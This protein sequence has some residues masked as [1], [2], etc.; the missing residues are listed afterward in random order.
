MSSRNINPFPEQRSVADVLNEVKDELK[1][2]A[3]TRIQMLRAEMN[4]RVGTLKMS[5]PM[6]SIGAFLGVV[7][8]VWF[9][10][11]LTFLIAQAFLPNAWAN[12]AAFLIVGVLYSAEAAVTL[13]FGY[14]SLKSKPIKPE[15][16][17][18]ILRDDQRW[19]QKETKRI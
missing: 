3:N 17:L 13:L 6:M 10:L 11:A 15:R 16:T 14:R 4:E 7:A 19:L 2:F 5:L 1:Q 8:F 18:K 9:S 12:A